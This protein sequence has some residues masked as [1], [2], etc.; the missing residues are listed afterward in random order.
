[1]LPSKNRLK[2]KSDIEKVLK[3]GRS[4]KEDFLVFKMLK[5]GP[6]DSK[7]G[8]IVST[9]VSKKAVVRNRIRRRLGELMLSKLKNIKTGVNGLFIAVPGIDKKDFW[10][11]DEAINKIFTKFKI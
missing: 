4:H 7:F 2:N 11:I 1:M 8:F 10:E 9:K 3:T 5:T 6:S